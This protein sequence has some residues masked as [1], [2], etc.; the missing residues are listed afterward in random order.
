[1]IKSR[2]FWIAATLIAVLPLLAI[3]IIQHYLDW[4]KDVRWELIDTVQ[5][6]YTLDRQ[7]KASILDKVFERNQTLTFLIYIKSFC[8]L[9]FLV[10]GIYFFKRYRQQQR[11]KFFKPFLYTI[12]LMVCFVLAKVVV[13][14]RINTSSDIHILTLNPADTSFKKLYEDNFKGKIV[15]IDFWGTTCGPC[16]AEFRDFT[17]PLKDKFK[18]RNDLSYLYIAQG[19]EYLWH[20][21][22]KKYNIKGYHL[23]VDEKQYENL[24]K[25]STKDSLVLMPHYL[26]L[27]RKG[28]VIEPDAKQPSNGDSLY[29]QLDKYLAQR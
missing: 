15:Y 12:T 3:D 27:D 23:F 16:L 19:N 21:Q 6:T 17:E 2:N 9:I 20:E 1:M 5:N 22:I 7:Q 4:Q 18:N 24:Y 25:K 14:N 26:I 28:N 29:V 10:F 8:S 13:V 11:P